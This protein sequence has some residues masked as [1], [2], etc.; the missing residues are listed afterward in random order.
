MITV[1]QVA[2]EDWARVRAIRLRSLEDAPDAFASTYQA[3]A[4][5]ASSFWQQRLSDPD[6]ATFLAAVE[7]ADIGITTGA[8]FV[9]KPGAAGLFG[10]WVDSSAR[11]TGVG[12]VLVRTVIDWAR[13]RGFDRVLLEVADYNHAA[14]ALYARHGFEPTGRRGTLPAPREHIWEHERVREL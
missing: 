5:A 3:E 13:A 6:A 2:A 1:N 10:M 8:A 14:I 11:G 4:Q 9:G 7:R 12:D